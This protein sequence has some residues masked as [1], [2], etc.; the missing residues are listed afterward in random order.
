MRNIDP[1]VAAFSY[2]SYIFYSNLSAKLCGKERLNDPELEFK[3]FVDMFTN[4]ILSSSEDG[5]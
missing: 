5:I 3:N 1:N 2:L 4:G